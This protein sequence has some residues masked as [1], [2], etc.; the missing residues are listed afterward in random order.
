VLR[1]GSVQQPVLEKAGDNLRIDWGYLYA[2][3]PHDD[4]ATY[5]GD[6]DAVRASFAGAGRCPTAT[7]SRRIASPGV[8]ASRWPSPEPERDRAALLAP[9]RARL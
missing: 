2:V 7:I 3:A 6:R 1:A 5:A 8:A 4:V 9:R